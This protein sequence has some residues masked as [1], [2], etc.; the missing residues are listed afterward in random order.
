MAAGD[1]TTLAACKDWLGITGNGDDGVLARLIT[2]VS[3]AIENIVNRTFAITAYNIM[4]NGT[5]TRRMVLPDFPVV[6]VTSVTVDGMLV[7][8]SSD[9]VVARG[10][11]FDD[12]GLFMVG[13]VFSMGRNNVRVVYSAGYAT[14]PADIDQACLEL[15]AFRYRGRDRIGHA[16]K[17]VQGETVSYITKDMPAEVAAT[18]AQYRKV[19]P[20]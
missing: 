19:V 15:V 12:R 16:S 1:L 6:S 13:G 17:S 4:R 14:V 7:S 5:G 20:S 18:L 9:G 11:T 10:W 8:Q 2:N 3:A